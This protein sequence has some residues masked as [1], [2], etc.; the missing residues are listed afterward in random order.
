M[1]L[2]TFSFLCFIVIDVDLIDRYIFLSFVKKP[3]NNLDY[4]QIVPTA[5]ILVVFF[6]CRKDIPSFLIIFSKF[7]IVN[8]IIVFGL[9]WI[10]FRLFTCFSS[11]STPLHGTSTY[12]S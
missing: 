6:G 7:Y 9:P 4:S 11:E 5:Y 1:L 8:I 2:C 10:L 12:P 3:Y